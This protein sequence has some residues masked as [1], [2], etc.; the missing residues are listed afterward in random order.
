MGAHENIVEQTQ[1]EN[2]K[3]CLSGIHLENGTSYFNHNVTS[4]IIPTLAALRR[5]RRRSR[6]VT[7]QPVDAAPWSCVCSSSFLP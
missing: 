2:G 7:R 1:T 3:V 6:R 5:R 4:Y